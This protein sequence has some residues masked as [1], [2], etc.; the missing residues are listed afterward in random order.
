MLQSASNF[1]DKKQVRFILI[2][3]YV[4]KYVFLSFIHI[5]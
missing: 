5:K 1:D 2:I 4:K 3:N